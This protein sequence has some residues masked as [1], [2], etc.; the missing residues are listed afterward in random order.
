M[1]LRKWL[2][3]S[4]LA[5]LPLVSGCAQHVA[6]APT[7]NAV[8]AIAAPRSCPPA[9]PAADAIAVGSEKMISICRDVWVDPST[10]VPDHRGRGDGSMFMTWGSSAGAACWKGAIEMSGFFGEISQMSVFDTELGPEKI[11]T[12]ARAGR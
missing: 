7:P 9:D 3:A 1:T 8:V 2:V 5:I 4:G 10:S 11:A 6:S 12:M